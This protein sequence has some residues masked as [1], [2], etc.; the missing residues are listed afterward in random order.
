MADNE[1]QSLLQVIVE[2]VDKV[3]EPL[4]KIKEDFDEFSES[5]HNIWAAGAE[6]FAGYEAIK[7]LVEPASDMVEAQTHLALATQFGAEQLAVMKDQAEKLSATLPQSIEDITGAQEELYKTFGKTQNLEDLT[8]MSA[9]LATVLGVNATSGANVLS[10]AYEQLGDKS[11]PAAE[12]L[13]IISDKLALLKDRY[14]K[15]GEASTLERDIQRI[16]KSAQA[17]GIS[18]NQMFGIWAE[19]NRLHA[20]GPRGF[21]MV[22]AS[23]FDTLAKSSKELSKAGLEVVHNSQGGVNMIATLERIN[24]MS[25][26]GKM[27]LFSELPGQAKVLVEFANHIQ[28]IKDTMGQFR[29][30]GGELEKASS[31][32]ANTPGA[33]L[34]I[35]KNQLSN[36][37]D[38]LGTQLLPPLIVIVTHLSEFLT[39][40]NQ[41]A[42][43]HP[44]LTQ[45]AA[46]IIAIVAGLLTM[47]GLFHFAEIIVNVILLGTKLAG[48]QEIWF[49]LQTALTEGFAEIGTAAA[50]AFDTNPVGLILTA[51]GLVVIALYEIYK[52]WDAITAATRGAMDA[53]EG[54]ASLSRQVGGLRTTEDVF[55]TIG[56]NLIH[57]GSAVSVNDVMRQD[58]AGSQSPVAA[59]IHN[60]LTIHVGPGTDPKAVADH[61]SDAMQRIGQE[62]AR[63]SFGDPTLAGAH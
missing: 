20:G 32:L 14:L 48:L 40:V 33:K 52:H 47:A 23:L 11:K 4:G 31:A 17:A 61:V 2:I 58:A 53:A 3:T 24:A 15:P 22:E 60:H 28:D 13:G 8:R 21:G 54:Y 41:F 10:A 34:E 51:L 55:K 59:A 50:I 49:V 63:T 57:P 16:G 45:I 39:Q 25:Q 26:S 9:R 37:A 12:Q 30:S 18:Q 1:E 42:E 62:Q 35:L 19:G 38:T 43:A 36:I 7:E 44:V 46:D 56:H 5:V 6:V 27:K 29:G